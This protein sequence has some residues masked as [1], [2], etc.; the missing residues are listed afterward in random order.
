VIHTEP[1]NDLRAHITNGD[2]C[3]CL[4]RLV[5]GCT[6][7]NSYDGRETGEVCRKAIDM[8]CL[9]IAVHGHKLSGA[10]LRAVHHARLI[11]DMHWPAKPIEVDP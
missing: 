4:P 5:D 8:L 2:P 1:V 6:V 11:L 10:D 3:P 9:A 7:H